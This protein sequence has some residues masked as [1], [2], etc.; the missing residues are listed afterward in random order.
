MFLEQ[1]EEAEKH[2]R[3]L[4]RL[5]KEMETQQAA[6]AAAAEQA[7]MREDLLTRALRISIQNN[8]DKTIVHREQVVDQPN[9]LLSLNRLTL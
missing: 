7:T 3:E 5:E 6:A 4:E 8:V 2:K 9:A 1:Q